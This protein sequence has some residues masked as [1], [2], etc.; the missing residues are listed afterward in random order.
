MYKL[1][2]PP[3]QKMVGSWENK[4]YPM[5]MGVHPWSGAETGGSAGWTLV[6]EQR[7]DSHIL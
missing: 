6:S 7:G 1:R 5:C 3:E 2:K 4:E